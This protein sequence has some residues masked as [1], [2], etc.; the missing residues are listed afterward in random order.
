MLKS[1]KDIKHSGL[2]RKGRLYIRSG[3]GVT[4]TRARGSC[5]RRRGRRE[6]RVEVGVLNAEGLEVGVGRSV[7]DEGER[8]GSVVVCRCVR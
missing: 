6:E 4:V 7:G 1:V 2:I 5:G 3:K 8:M